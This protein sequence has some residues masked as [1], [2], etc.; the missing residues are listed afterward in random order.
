MQFFLARGCTAHLL[1]LGADVF[2]PPVPEDE[3]RDFH[4]LTSKTHAVKYFRVPEWMDTDKAKWKVS[5]VLVFGVLG[6]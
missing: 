2:V 3:L 5:D 4:F 1:T 6:Q